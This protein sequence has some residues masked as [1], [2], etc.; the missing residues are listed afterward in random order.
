M[1]Q[2]YR[3][4]VKREVRPCLDGRG[5][6]HHWAIDAPSEGEQFKV[7]RCSFCHGEDVF[8]VAFP[9]HMLGRLRELERRAAEK[10][11]LDDVL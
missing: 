3:D 6:A 7:G 11:L 5:T 1:K 10:E 9:E 8:R 4:P 2:R